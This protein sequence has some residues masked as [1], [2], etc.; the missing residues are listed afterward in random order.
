M[1]KAIKIGGGIAAVLMLIGACGATS[2]EES[3]TETKT[4]AVETGTDESTTA[5]VTE[6]EVTRA[7]ENALRSAESYLEFSG[8]SKKGLIDQL[9]SEYADDYDKAD[10]KWAVN[11]LDVD[12]NEQA[13]RSGESYLDMSGFSR[14]GLI[15]Q[16]SS[17]YADNYTEVQATYAADKLGL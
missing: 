9:S 8:F 5:E 3:A 15:E 12:W 17:Q 1:N 4:V 14:Q 10:A 11:Q 2:S 13:V 16:L 6:P 7:Q